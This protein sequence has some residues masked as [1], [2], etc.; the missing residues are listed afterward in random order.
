MKTDNASDLIYNIEGNQI[1][2]ARGDFALG[3]RIQYP[4]KYSLS[5]TD[6]E[7]LH[8]AWHKALKNL[9][10]GTIVVK[11]DIYTK[12]RCDTTG[13]P[14][15]NFMQKATKRYFQGRE[16]MNHVGYLFFVF[17][18]HN[19]MKNDSLKN[20]F[21]FPRIEQF[22]KEDAERSAFINEVHQAV[23]IIG[24]SDLIR[25]QPLCEKE[26]SSYCDFYFNGFQSDYFT[27]LETKKDHIQ[28]DE[29]YIGV[30]AITHEKNLPDTLSPALIESKCSYNNQEYGFYKGF[31][32]D[33]D[34][35]LC[36]DHIYNQIV[37]IDS[38]K[39]HLDRVA[40]NREMLYGARKLSPENK[41]GA[42]RLQE[43]ID[44]VCDDPQYHYVRGHN[45]IIFWAETKDE[46]QRQKNKIASILKNKDIKPL[47]LTKENMQ[48]VFYNSFFTNVSCLNNQAM[49]LADLR[50]A[51]CLF[52]T[53]TNY[54][55]DKEGIILCDR[56]FN[57]PIVYDFWDREKIRKS[58]RNFAI[59]SKTGSGKSFTAQH[60]F[61]Q[62]IAE[63]V[64]HIIIDMGDSYLKMSKLFPKEECLMIKYQPG[65]SLGLN[66]FGLV[67]DE[68][69]SADKIEEL[70]EF[71]WT[72]IKKTSEASKDEQ[73]SLRKILQHYYAVEDDFCWE[74]FYR[75]IDLNRDVVCNLADI[76]GTRYFDVDEFLHAGSDFM[77]GGLYANLL[78]KTE[79][80]S[81]GFV[82]KKLIIF[83]L[84]GVKDNPLVLSLLL[85]VISEALNKTIWQDRTTRGIVFYD[86]FAKQ[87]EFPEVFQRVKYQM[88]TIRKYNGA[89]GI[90]LQ[91]LDQLP[92]NQMGNSMLAN[93]DTYIFLQEGSY[94]TSIKRIGITDHD[95]CQLHSLSNQF[96]GTPRYSEIFIRNNKF[97][98]VYRIEVPEEVYLAFQTEGA[99]HEEIL[100]NYA[101][102]QDMELAIRRYMDNHKN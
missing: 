30:F 34:M 57:R 69:V 3:Y 54:K 91:N 12:E 93:I 81:V 87:L 86:E 62:L 65:E 37:F 36:C 66:P 61:T 32:D 6:F 4:E 96:S 48:N 92:E 15:R 55:S 102:T 21:V 75:F 14:E 97:S 83:E 53:S 26:I 38:H 18:K 101:Q 43:Y 68:P 56:I 77:P 11:S 25:L 23:D 72:L 19:T 71:I 44:E 88:Q 95:I 31:M 20:P 2:C 22:E 8:Q 27:D 51:L 90:V 99:I 64:V 33:L 98:N 5:E 78:K 10:E 40:K 39:S 7:T 24:R 89:A 16:Y 94:T 29:K 9:P 46:L 50:I 47:Y 73:T 1:L 67:G 49:F 63:G 82:G 74:S 58:A 79:D 42:D 85:Q 100:R 41:V 35:T 45:D 76:E 80:A 13:F 59:I 60:I 17:T 84:D 70:C 28:A 52:I